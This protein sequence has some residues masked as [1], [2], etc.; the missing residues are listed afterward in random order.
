LD[1]TAAQVL[2]ATRYRRPETWSFFVGGQII[3]GNTSDVIS[4]V[5]AQFHV[6][7]G[8]G[9]SNFSTALPLPQGIGF[10]LLRPVPWIE[11]QWTIAAGVAPATINTSKKWTS[12]ARTPLLQDAD[13]TSRQAVDWI[14]GQDIQIAGQVGLELSGVTA[15][16]NEI[17]VQ[18]SAY[19]AP[20]T[21][22][23]P[24]WFSGEE[25]QP[26]FLGAE[27]GGT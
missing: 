17:I 18:L 5:V 24:E 19:L 6:T 25:D 26:Q 22:I 8:A 3:G 10:P 23:R 16:N 20:R 9:L 13:A 1:V 27:T 14:V 11:M 21:H 4:T 15:V 2:A 12:I 7:T